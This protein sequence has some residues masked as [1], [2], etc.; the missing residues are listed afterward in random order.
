VVNVDITG[1]DPEGNLSSIGAY[2]SP[3]SNQDWNQIDGTQNC[4]GSTCSVSIPWDTSPVALG[5]YYVVGNIYDADAGQCSGNPW[6]P[7]PLGWSECPACGVIRT[8]EEPIIISDA[9]YQSEGGDVH[10]DD[11]GGG[12]IQSLIPQDCVDADDAV[13]DA[14]FSLPGATGQPGVVSYS[15]GGGADFGDGF[16]SNDSKTHWLAESDYEGDEGDRYDFAYFYDLV[17]SPTKISVPDGTAINQ[18]RLDIDFSEEGIVAYEGDIKT[19][20]TWNMTDKPKAV[21]FIDGKFLLKHRIISDP[22]ES[23]IVIATGGIGISDDYV[24]ELGNPTNAIFITDGMFYSGV[25]PAAFPGSFSPGE[26]GKKLTING[27]VIAWGGFDFSGRDFSFSDEPAEQIR[28][29]TEPVEFY[30]YDP[31]LLLDSNEKLWKAGFTWQELA[32]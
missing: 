28:N 24:A 12:D 26:A 8:I 1:T 7:L 22:G 20:S 2:Y 29:N 10:A 19:G 16:C 5:S 21:I 15:T 30:R 14:N 25:D 18:E 31:S 23:I 6:T 27:S 9:W 4:S 3:T 17:G 11:S 32:P 13:C